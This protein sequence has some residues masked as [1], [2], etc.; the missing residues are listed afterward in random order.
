[1]KSLKKNVVI[2]ACMLA[3]SMAAYAQSSLAGKWHGTE[4]NLPTVDLTIE[5]NAGQATEMPS[6]T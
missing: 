6:S 3:A 4:N 5:E 2:I 1:M